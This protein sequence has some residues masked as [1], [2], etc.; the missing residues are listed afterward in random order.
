MKWSEKSVLVTGASGFIGSHLAEALVKKGAR[1][2]AFV[3]Y[4]A[5][6]SCGWLDKSLLRK[7]MEIVAGDICDTCQVASAMKGIDI[8]FHLAALIG[9]PYSYEATESYVRTNIGGTLNVLQTA[10]QRR[11]ERLLF[12]STSEVY[13]SA[14][15]VPIDE[16][17]PLRAQSPYAAS[18]IGADK[19]VEA[20]HHSFHLPTVIVRPFNTFGPRQSARA[21]VPSILLQCLNGRKIYLGHLHPMRDLN[22][23]DDVVEGF[24]CAVSSPY[25]MG[26]TI[27]I[28]SGKAISIQ[29]LV[30]LIAKLLHRKITIQSDGRRMRPDQ[31]EVDRLEA[32]N[33]LACKLTGWRP[34]YSLEDGLR[35]TIDWMRANIEK[36]KYIDYA[37]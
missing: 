11:F 20:F 24:L 27:N 16:D 21:I 18:K 30:H 37:L 28:G 7:K 3:H 9:I 25:A 23:V 26:Q 32:N 15:Y 22:Y 35:L 29:G 1:T 17:H 8:V 33:A 36:Y 14:L 6:G 12:T 34:N 5:L 4:N 19:L 31:S 10:R 13:G 2:R